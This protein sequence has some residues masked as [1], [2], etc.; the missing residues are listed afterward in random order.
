MDGDHHTGMLDV[1]CCFCSFPAQYIA[2]NSEQ[3]QDAFFR[4]R[5]ISQDGEQYKSCIVLFIIP[6]PTMYLFLW[7]F[8]PNCKRKTTYSARMSMAIV[9]QLA[10]SWWCVILV[11]L[12]I[13]YHSL[14]VGYALSH[15][16]L[17]SPNIDRAHTIILFVVFCTFF[18]SLLLIL[19]AIVNIACTSFIPF[20]LVWYIGF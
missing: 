3:M 10:F 16:S 11:L 6:L 4:W 20:M 1:S 12:W 9:F 13:E 19:R 18:V 5:W 2:E 14:H 8:S 15:R 17:I 7:F